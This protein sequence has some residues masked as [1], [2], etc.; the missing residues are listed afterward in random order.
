MFV[1]ADL[2]GAVAFTFLAL[3]RVN[4]LFDSSFAPIFLVVTLNP[5]RHL[6]WLTVN[7]NRLQV[8]TTEL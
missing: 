8:I 1:R 6:G 3:E 7:L 4:A 5:F 2:L